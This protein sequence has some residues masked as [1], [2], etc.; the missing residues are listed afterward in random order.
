M[1]EHRSSQA[2]SFGS[3]LFCFALFA[4]PSHQQSSAQAKVQPTT[5][6]TAWELPVS[7]PN[8]QTAN[9]SLYLQEAGDL[10]VPNF[11][12]YFQSRCIIGQIYPY[13]NSGASE[14]GWVDSYPIFDSVY[15]VGNAWVSAWALDTGD[16]LIII[17]A[18]DNAD[19][20][21]EI[22]IPG[23]KTFGFEGSDIKAVIVTHEHADHYGGARWL[24]DTFDVPVYMSEAA[25]DAINDDPANPGGLIIPPARNLTIEDGVGITV[26]NVTVTPI[27]TPG[28]TEGT[29]SLLFPVYD[30][31]V[32]HVAALYGGNGIPSDAGLKDKQIK[33][34]SKF[35]VK[36]VEHGV[37]VLMGNHA[38]QDD[39]LSNLEILKT[40]PANSCGLTNP[41]IMSTGDYVRYL[42]MHAACVRVLAARTDQVL[43]V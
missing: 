39:A 21:R 20:A 10:S 27:L 41:F 23:I 43:Q 28:H 31:G 14:P 18:L 37:D 11:R 9:V 1:P 5:N 42:Q 38:N 33:S 30:Q 7:F 12:H 6:F 17:D 19:E 15:F 36:A 24:Q 26:G 4:G 35:A 13:L 16:G 25:W 2:L 29:V 32:K 34:Y 40:R 22:I 3:L 8:E